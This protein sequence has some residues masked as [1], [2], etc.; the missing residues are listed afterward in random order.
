MV[1]RRMLIVNQNNFFS[2]LEIIK[3]QIPLFGA[4]E[5]AKR[6]AL[7]RLH[8][9]LIT[10]FKQST[11]VKILTTPAPILVNL[12]KAR[13]R[14][15]RFDF[16]LINARVCWLQK[17]WISLA[18][19]SAMRCLLHFEFPGHHLKAINWCRPTFVRLLI[20]KQFY[21]HW[22]FILLLLRY[23]KMRSFVESFDDF[24]FL[25]DVL[26]SWISGVSLCFDVY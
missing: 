23:E 16:R 8:R 2:K 25:F 18:F 19:I 26:K 12:H 10:L 3:I 22:G 20:V 14:L 9:F 13:L 7:L 5:K 4:K 6:L 21:L 1:F 24:C 17:E 15:W 11:A